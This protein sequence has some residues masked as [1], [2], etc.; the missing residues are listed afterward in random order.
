MMPFSLL[1][2]ASNNHPSHLLLHPPQLAGA[3][4][5]PA[6]RRCRRRSPAGPRLVICRWVLDKGCSAPFTHLLPFASTMQGAA[7]LLELHACL[8]TSSH[9]SLDCHAAAAALLRRPGIVAA[10]GHK[11]RQRRGRSGH[12]QLTNKL[13]QRLLQCGVAGGCRRRTAPASPAG[14]CRLLQLFAA[15]IFQR[16]VILLLTHW[17]C[18]E[19]RHGRGGSPGGK[20]MQRRGRTRRRRGPERGSPGAQRCLLRLRRS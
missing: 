9:L 17:R 14:A 19:S 2:N 8:R 6:A 20:Q 13:S 3:G 18:T 5:R 15:L 7:A 1:P 16:V 4:V 11:P 12:Q 10:C